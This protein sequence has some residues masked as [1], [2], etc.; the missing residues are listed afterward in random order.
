MEGLPISL[1]E[2]MSMGVVPVSTP[3]G[4]VCDVIR[5]CE[6]GYISFSH[7]SEDY[8]KTIKDAIA[9]VGG[10]TSKQIIE[11]YKEKY[12]M[13]ACAKAYTEEFKK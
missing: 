5:N 4:G 10:V 1:L 8:Y 12:S 3:A 9:N 7:S 6:N 2:A 11:E 13:I